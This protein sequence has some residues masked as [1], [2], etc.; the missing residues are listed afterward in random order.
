MTSLTTKAAPGR[1]EMRRSGTSKHDDS[2]A[3]KLKHGDSGAQQLREQ[4]INK[5]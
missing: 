3:Q 4:R 1:D 2:D 5:Q